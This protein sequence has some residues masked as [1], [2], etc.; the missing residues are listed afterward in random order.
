MDNKK[1][2]IFLLM[3]IIWSWTFWFIGLYLL[4]D[5]INQES[6]GKFLI[7]FFS[8]VYGPSISAI[9]TT[10]IFD[11]IEGVLNLLKK[12][13]IWNVP[14]KNYLYIIILPTIF[15]IIGIG[16]YSIFIGDIGSFDLMAFV[17][18]P[19][20]LWAGIYAGPLGEELGWRGFLLSELKKEQSNLKSAII[21]GIIWFIWHIP[22]WWAPFGTLVSG[23]SISF[24]PIITYFLMLICLSIIIT[25]LVIN[26]KGSVF[27]ALLF[28]LSINAGIALLFFPELQVTF[29]KVHLLSSVGMIIFT[30]FLILKNKLKTTT[31]V[32]QNK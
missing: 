24:L 19:A 16:L 3:T 5:E 22:L 9:V 26:S 11:G 31:G 29:K 12:L 21:I 8:G 13:F 7:F 27:V 32:L 20:V 1:T 4:K 14:L 17:S 23:E 18:I 28:H 10:F 30:G 6:I 15:V 25:W 2:Y